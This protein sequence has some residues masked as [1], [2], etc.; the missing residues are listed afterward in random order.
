M[1]SSNSPSLQRLKDMMRKK[2]VEDEACLHARSGIWVIPQVHVKSGC[3]V[4]RG[5]GDTTR[6]KGLEEYESQPNDSQLTNDTL[7]SSDQNDLEQDM[8]AID[9][10]LAK[11]GLEALEDNPPG[12]PRPGDSPTLILGHVG[13]ISPRLMGEGDESSSYFMGEGDESSDEPLACDLSTTPSPCMDEKPVPKPFPRPREVDGDDQIPPSQWSPDGSE[14]EGGVKQKV[15]KYVSDL[16]LLNHVS[17]T[18]HMSFPQSLHCSRWTISC[19]RM[20]TRTQNSPPT[21]RNMRS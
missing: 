18:C 16:R 17:Y 15:P 5:L 2:T 13:E 11:D 14:S 7:P 3:V 12:V 10:L 21:V 1:T 19:V 8:K 20:L 6:H 4:G 9:F